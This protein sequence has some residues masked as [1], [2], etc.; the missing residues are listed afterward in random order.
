[1][2]TWKQVAMLALYI[3]G[4]LVSALVYM[5]LTQ[6]EDQKSA[7]KEKIDAYNKLFAVVAES[8]KIMEIVKNSLKSST[9]SQKDIEVQIGKLQKIIRGCKGR[10]TTH[11]DEIDE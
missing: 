11:D 9:E 7:E 2:V 5:Y 3:I 6:R 1:M 4:A 10:N 8:T